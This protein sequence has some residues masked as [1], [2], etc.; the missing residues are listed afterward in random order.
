MGQGLIGWPPGHITSVILATTPHDLSVV[1]Q[2]SRV[3]DSEDAST[4]G[5]SCPLHARLDK[6]AGEVETLIG[7]ALS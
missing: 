5:L 1:S 4:I 7:G 6:V 3:R 2:I